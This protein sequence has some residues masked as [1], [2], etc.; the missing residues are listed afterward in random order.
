MAWLHTWAGL[1]LGWVLFFIFLTGTLGYFDTEIDDWMQPERALVSPPVSLE[2][3]VAVAM[4]RLKEVAPQARRWYISPP[5]D[6]EYRELRIYYEALPSA[7]E[8]R[9]KSD[10]ELLSSVTGEPLHYRETGGG[11]VL[12]QLHWRLHYVPQML[13]VW[14]VGV[15]A[16]F[17]LVAIVSG[18]IVHKRI[19]RDFFTFR[20]GR[21]PRSW[22]DAHNVLSVLALPFHF[23][24]TYSGLIFYATSYMPL[25]AAGNYGVGAAQAQQVFAQEFYTDPAAVAPAGVAAPLTDLKPLLAS[26]AAR[27]GEKQIRFV[28]IRN[29]GDARARVVIG[30]VMTSPGF[31]EQIMF[32]GVSGKVLD[33][34]VSTRAPAVTRDVLLGLHEGLFAT[35]LLRGI[36]FFSGLLG[37]AMIAT[38]LVLWTV[39]RKTKMGAR[40]KA[41]GPVE[42]VNVGTIVGLPVAIAAYF[43]ANR[44][45]P[46][47]L[48][49]R[50]EWEVHA[51]F[52]TWAAMLL[53]AHVRPLSKIWRE[54]FWIAGAAYAFLPLLNML[55]TER[56]L[57][58]TIPHGAWGLAAV[59]LSMLGA[60]LVFAA[61]AYLLHLKAQD[62]RY[63]GSR[64]RR[65]MPSL[66]PPPSGGG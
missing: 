51:L 43:W 30:R 39:K 45:I 16:M 44:L 56:H 46:A 15:C 1:T 6:R 47:D 34:P 58:V 26:A 52:I 5:F 54:Q 24:I 49:G 22:L 59:D 32:D 27:W 41:I 10:V 60:G 17:M 28:D 63:L 48:P 50:G 33:A 4:G 3:S 12:Y 2:E 55:T 65:A 38:G 20:P 57:G 66:E 29:P 62:T 35:P 61:T 31:S 8:S 53:H 13:A 64:V 14:I 37:T 18:V 25:I 40:S 42:R 9:V 23:M 11:Q 7:S 36:Y 21:Q 19:F